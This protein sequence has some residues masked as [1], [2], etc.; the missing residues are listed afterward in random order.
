MRIDARVILSRGDRSD[1]LRPGIEVVPGEAGS[2]EQQSRP[3]SL[4][5][6]SLTISLDRVLADQ[7]AAVLS[8]SG[9]DQGAP[10]TLVLEVTRKPL[11]NLVWLGAIL[12]TLGGCLAYFH[13]G[14][15]QKG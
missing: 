15:G 14:G 9:L 8:V 1:T 13:R 7:G 2:P 6:D 11:I 5:G 4:D 10:E 3:A 12:I